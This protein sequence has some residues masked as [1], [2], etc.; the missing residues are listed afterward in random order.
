MRQRKRRPT[1]DARL[2][3][4]LTL[5]AAIGLVL[6]L[7]PLLSA[8]NGGGQVFGIPVIGLY[9]FVAWAVIITLVAVLVRGSG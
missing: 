8:F 6:L 2:T 3:A 7:P 4:R 5:V 1:D 9:L